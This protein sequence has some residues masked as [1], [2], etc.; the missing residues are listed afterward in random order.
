MKP[1][2]T[3]KRDIEGNPITAGAQEKKIPHKKQEED[4]DEPFDQIDQDRKEEKDELMMEDV[5]LHVEA[6]PSKTDDGADEPGFNSGIWL[7]TDRDNITHFF[8]PNFLPPYTGE[9]RKLIL[10]VLK[11]EWDERTLSWKPCGEGSMTKA[12]PVEAPEISTMSSSDVVERGGEF[13]SSAAQS[14]TE[15]ALPMYEK[16]NEMLGEVI[17]HIRDSCMPPGENG[18]NVNKIEDNTAEDEATT[19][20]EQATETQTDAPKKEQD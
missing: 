20:L 11:E 15:S 5:N 18:S 10:D 8:E 19:S 12:K 1:L 17:S 14:C 16:A 3:V 4:H 9:K 13:I 2:N 7:F 6:G